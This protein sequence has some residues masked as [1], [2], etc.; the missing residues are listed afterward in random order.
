MKTLPKECCN[1]SC[2][3]VFHTNPQKFHQRDFCDGCAEQS[4]WICTDPDAGQYRLDEGQDVWR[5]TRFTFKEGDREET[6][7]LNDYT[8]EEIQSYVS[9]YGYVALPHNYYFIDG[10]QKE[11]DNSIIAECIFEMTN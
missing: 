9:A 4:N 1:R 10:T 2:S 3:N 11:V 7:D 5:D 8:R 6:I